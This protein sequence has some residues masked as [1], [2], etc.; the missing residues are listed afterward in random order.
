MWFGEWAPEGARS[1]GERIF[2]GEWKNGGGSE[3]G[4]QRALGAGA[5]EFFWE[6]GAQRE[7][8]FSCEIGA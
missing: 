6:I 1:G 3:R 5:R 8:E 2:L 7:R 4:R